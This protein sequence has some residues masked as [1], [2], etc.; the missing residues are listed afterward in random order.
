MK[1]LNFPLTL[2]R[3]GGNLLLEGHF[4]MQRTDYGVGSG[5]WSNGKTIALKVK[6]EFS[7]TLTKDHAGKA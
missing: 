4:T 2:K 5:Q 3:Q 6:V 1:P 7:I